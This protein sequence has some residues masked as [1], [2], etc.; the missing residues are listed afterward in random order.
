M[1]CECDDETDDQ[2]GSHRHRK[3]HD[4]GTT[5][6]GPPGSFILVDLCLRPFLLPCG[7]HDRIVRRPDGC[8]REEAV[9]AVEG[10]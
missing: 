1:D 6:R 7:A 10:V 4:G 9:A 2:A 8:F 3:L 5:R